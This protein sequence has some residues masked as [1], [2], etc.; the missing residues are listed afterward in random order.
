[1]T[2]FIEVL[3]Y[4]LPGDEIYIYFAFHYFSILDG[5]HCFQSTYSKCLYLFIYLF[6]LAGNVNKWKIRKWPCAYLNLMWCIKIDLDGSCK[7]GPTTS[8]IGYKRRIFII[9]SGECDVNVAYKLV[10][11]CWINWQLWPRT[12]QDSSSRRLTR[13]ATLDLT[14]LTWP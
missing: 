7:M 2:S 1:M 8:I 13:V 12:Q 14:C 9:K 4:I 5:K 11:R 3:K 6:Y 10:V